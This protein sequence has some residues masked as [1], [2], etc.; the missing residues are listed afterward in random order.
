[1]RRPGSLWLALM[2]IAGG[3]RA[4]ADCPAVDGVRSQA[5]CIHDQMA[6]DVID[7][8]Y[9]LALSTVDGKLDPRH[10]PMDFRYIAEEAGETAGRTGPKPLIEMA[11]SAD[12]G[13]LAF[14]ARAINAFLDAVHDGHSHRSQYQGK[15]N[16]KLYA[17]AKPVLRAPCKH[18]A[19][20]D[21]TFVRNEGEICLRQVDPPPPLPWSG[22]DGPE[23]AMR[24]LRETVGTPATVSSGQGGLRAAGSD[25]PRARRTSK[26]RSKTAAKK[27]GASPSP[28]P[29]ASN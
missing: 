11:S 20:S 29:P 10:V 16:P 7:R 19:A 12:L 6:P 21:N 1:M 24:S 14:A 23:D 22:A 13:K 28:A 4:A 26:P 17:D 2:M 5:E 27:Q 18:L 15:D 8:L 9:R 3:A 25:P